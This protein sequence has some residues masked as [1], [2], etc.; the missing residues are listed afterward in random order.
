MCV[1]DCVHS[2]CFFSTS[3]L[4]GR[5]SLVRVSWRKNNVEASSCRVEKRIGL[6]KELN[7]NRL[8]T[9]DNLS[10]WNKMFWLFYS[11]ETWNILWP[12]F[13][14]PI[15]DYEIPQTSLRPHRRPPLPRHISIKSWNVFAWKAS[16][17]KALISFY[18]LGVPTW[19]I[20]LYLSATLV[21]HISPCDSTGTHS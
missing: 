21:W 8:W 15:S 1:Y 19:N 17:K 2:F 12:N 16:R 6:K 5:C 7:N 11:P 9:E 14:Q 3:V 13:K 10:E 20:C 4:W 18:L